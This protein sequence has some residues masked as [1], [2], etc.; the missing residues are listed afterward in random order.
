MFI[1]SDNSNLLQLSWFVTLV[2]MVPL[3]DK[4]ARAFGGLPIVPLV[5]NICTIGTNG[6]IGN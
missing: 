1:Y 4:I 6:I 5:G 2:K 3:G